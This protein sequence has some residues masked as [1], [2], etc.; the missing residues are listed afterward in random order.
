MNIVLL[1]GGSGKR[2]WPLSN[3]TRSKQ[4][5]QLLE[6]DNGEYESMLQ[7]IFRQIKEADIDSNVVVA[8]AQTQVDSIR[9]QLG[10]EVEL[11]VEPQRRNTFPAI[12]LST[13]YLAME[14]GVDL[15]ETVVVLPVDPYVENEYFHLL[16]KMDQA[17]Q[18][19]EADLV[20]MGI[21]PTYPSAKYGYILPCEKVISESEEKAYPVKQYIEKPSEKEAAGL[22]EAG[23][24]WNA[25]VFAFK[26]GYFMDKLKTYLTVTDYGD[27]KK[28]Y[29]ELKK[30]SFDYEVVEKEKSIAAVPYTK[31]WKDLGTWNTITEEMQIG[32]IGEVIIDETTENTHVINELSVPMIVMGAKDMII[33]ASPDGILVSDKRQ[34]SY[35]KPYVEEL[36]NRPMFEERRWGEY[37]VLD[38][39]TYEDG[40]K[41]LT[42]HL[43]MNEGENISYQAHNIRDEIWTIVDGE[44]LLV[45]D[46]IV[47]KV[48]RGDVAYIK[49]GQKHAMKAT[50]NLH[51]IEVQIGDDLVEE[52]ILRF[53]WDWSCF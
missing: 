18:E 8:T 21:N 4:F 22:I 35:I 15:E 1:S 27:M 12:A 46:D 42:K 11:V 41:S 6:N 14:K 10:K 52:D 48:V 43:R 23:A 28:R 30:I 7:R 34:S 53:D 29:Q 51:F 25:G 2:L 19:K 50:K 13:C 33:A 49:K 40:T 47:K 45:I 17:V 39:V 5:L 24:L 38:Y 36:D 26:L 20:L 44:G 37:K 3:D 32:G 31:E 16:K 9:N